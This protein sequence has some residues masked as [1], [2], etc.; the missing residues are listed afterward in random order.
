MAAHPKLSIIWKEAVRFRPG[1]IIFLLK[2][3]LMEIEMEAILDEN[4][5]C[6]VNLERNGMFENLILIVNSC[7]QKKKEHF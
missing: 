4:F 3:I 2:I 5:C 6:K 7:I 1:V